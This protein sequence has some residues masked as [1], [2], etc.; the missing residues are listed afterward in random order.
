MFDGYVLSCSKTHDEADEYVPEFA[1]AN[2]QYVLANFSFCFVPLAP[3]Q[4]E[5]RTNGDAA[6]N[7]TN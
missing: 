5:N 2:V 7:I 3:V 6:G 4:A 1:A